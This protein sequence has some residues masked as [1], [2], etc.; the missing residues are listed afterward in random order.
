MRWAGDIERFE[1]IYRENEFTLEKRGKGGI[2]ESFPA[3]EIPFSSPSFKGKCV[4]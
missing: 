4:S 2:S 3:K 1:N